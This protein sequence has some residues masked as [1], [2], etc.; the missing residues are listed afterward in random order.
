MRILVVVAHPDDETN[1][2]G[3]TIARLSKA[4]HEVQL[5]VTTTQNR[6]GDQRKSEIRAA[7]RIVGINEPKFLDEPDLGL[8]VTVE[9]G[10][11]LGALLDIKPDVVFTLWGIDVHPDHRNTFSL[12]VDRYL[13]KG[14]NTELFCMELCSSGRSS[15]LVRP[16]SLAFIPTHYV[17]VTGVIGAKKA[18]QECHVSQDPCGMWLGVESMLRNR[19]AEF[20]VAFAEAFVRLTRSG[21]PPQALAEILRPSPWALPRSIGPEF[22]AEAVT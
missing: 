20:G 4:G 10:E 3:G 9:V 17:D 1:G 6:N 16:Q 22:L 11:K 18:M 2:M 7:A 14:A 19:G 5:V 13:K 8:N 12:T 15:P 21:E